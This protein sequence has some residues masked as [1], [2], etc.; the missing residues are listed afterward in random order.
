MRP[1]VPLFAML[2]LAIAPAST[3]ADPIIEL[4]PTILDFGAVPLSTPSTRLVTV[5]NVGGHPLT[6][7]AL[8]MLTGSSPDFSLI[9]PPVVPFDIQPPDPGHPTANELSITVRYLPSAL[10]PA[11]GTVVFSCN[12]PFNCPAIVSLQG[13]GV[14][15][16]PIPEPPA[17][18]LWGLLALLACAWWARAWKA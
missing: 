9:A 10:G 12:D 7:N 18:A 17:L 1:I 16:E 14:Q 3:W 6:V 2:C 13:V 15:V 5:S 4:D 11:T 8:F